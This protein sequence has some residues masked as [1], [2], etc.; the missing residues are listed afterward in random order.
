M[1]SGW[2]ASGRG[3]VSWGGGVMRMIGGGNIQVGRGWKWVASDRIDWEWGRAGKRGRRW[4]WDGAGRGEREV[5]V[6]GMRKWGSWSRLLRVVSDGKEVIN[7]AVWK[8]EVTY[9]CPHGRD[10]LDVYL[11]VPLC[12][13]LSLYMHVHV[14]LLVSVHVWKGEREIVYSSVCVPEPACDL[15][16]SKSVI[17]FSPNL[18]K[19]LKHSN[20]L[21][22][23]A[24]KL[25]VVAYFYKTWSY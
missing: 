24:F 12:N 18:A 21:I 7:E 20:R 23:K 6:I 16:R 25:N 11:A 14:C 8:T 19:L 15:R 4:G 3:C 13:Q 22:H 10:I 17:D 9:F 5:L 2:P 1:H